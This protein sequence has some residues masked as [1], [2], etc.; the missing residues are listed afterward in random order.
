MEDRNKIRDGDSRRVGRQTI[1]INIRTRKRAHSAPADLRK[2]KSMIE[3]YYRVDTNE[4]LVLPGVPTYDEDWSRDLH[5]FFN[6]IVLVSTHMMSS[7]II[8]FESFVI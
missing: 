3:D 2:K 5:D 7:S 6:L 1:G 8:H 4:N